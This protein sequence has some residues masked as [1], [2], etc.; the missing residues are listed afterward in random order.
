MSDEETILRRA[1]ARAMRLARNGDTSELV[2]LLRNWG[3]FS[4]EFRQ[5]VADIIEGKIKR[6]AHRPSRRYG[7]IVDDWWK[8]PN[9][10]AANRAWNYMRFWQKHHGAAGMLGHRLGVPWKAAPNLN[11]AIRTAIRRC[12]MKS[13]NDPSPNFDQIA[14]LIRRG[15]QFPPV[16]RK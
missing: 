7:D 5:F 4:S 9:N 16:P 15:R 10:R 12:K 3:A 11:D 1:E 14:D 8:K 13:P 2:Q 6:P